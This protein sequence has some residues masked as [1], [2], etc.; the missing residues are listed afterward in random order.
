M[1]SIKSYLWMALAGR[2][3]DLNE[4][5][6]YYLDRSY[7]STVRLIKLVNDMLNISRIESGRIILDIVEKDLKEL[8]DESMTEVKPRADEMKVDIVPDYDDCGGESV[9]VDVDKIKEV[10]VNL[11]GNA[12][13]FTSPG[14]VVTV[15]TR[16]N[17]DMV[18]ISIKDTGEG[19]DPEDIE[20]L[21]QKFGLVKESYVTNQNASQGTGLGLYI[22]KSI[23]ELHKGKIWV[24]SQGHGKGATFSFTLKI[25]N[26]EDLFSF[27]S[28]YVG[29]EGLGIIRTT[30]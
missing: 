10:L 15:T 2:G 24:E 4:K 6:R 28:Q 21:F 29:K 30:I 3:G 25:S 23:V 20:K 12:I 17:E 9:L 5:Q 26:P 11:L 27:R 13:K 19:L 7:N 22:S 16:K 14:G 18:T 8:L 1:T